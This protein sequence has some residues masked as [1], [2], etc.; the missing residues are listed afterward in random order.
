MGIDGGHFDFPSI[1][2]RS[3]IQSCGFQST[4]PSHSRTLHL[5]CLQFS[6]AFEW[7][8][9]I[10]EWDLRAS[11][12]QRTTYRCWVNL[13][14]F[15][16]QWWWLRLTVLMGYRYSRG[17]GTLL[18]HASLLPLTISSLR[19]DWLWDVYTHSHPLCLV[20][21]LQGLVGSCPGRLPHIL[22][23]RQLCSDSPCS[24]AETAAG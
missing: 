17:L 4:P 16:M 1:L 12:N 11:L 21:R 8:Y 6:V 10:F 24:V 9:H 22:L 15:Q 14:F 5:I 23:L 7:R 3:V 20:N 18:F 19:G 13:V 2:G